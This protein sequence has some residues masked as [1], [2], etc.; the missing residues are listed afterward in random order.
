MIKT[1]K[2]V[3]LVL[4]GV[5]GFVSGVLLNQC[6]REP[7]IVEVEKPIE[8]IKEIEKPV[9]VVKVI[10]KVVYKEPEP[11]VYEA[12]SLVWSDTE[13]TDEK[14]K[15]ILEDGD[16]YCYYVTKDDGNKKELRLR[17]VFHK[18]ERFHKM[19]AL[20]SYPIIYSAKVLGE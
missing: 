8:I 17:R 13:F 4:M 11:M 3:E 10:E 20:G 2:K 19:D 6:T 7:K 9:E 16:L 12:D 1:N 18:G 15:E 5:I 14:A